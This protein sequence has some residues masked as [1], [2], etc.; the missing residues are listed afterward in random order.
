[1]GVTRTGALTR[2]IE[3]QYGLLVSRAWKL[4]VLDSRRKVTRLR[5]YD[6]PPVEG[7]GGFHE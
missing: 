6:V 3:D 5:A 2:A 4:I 1:M 7:A